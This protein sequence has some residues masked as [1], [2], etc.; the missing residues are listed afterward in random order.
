M[1]AA[2]VHVPDQEWQSD[3]GRLLTRAKGIIIVPSASDGTIWELEYIQANSILSKCLFVM[4][5]QSRRF[6]WRDRWELARGALADDSVYLPAYHSRGLLFTLRDDSQVKAA[7]PF[8]FSW[9]WVL[10]MRILRMLRSRTRA[11]VTSEQVVR[12]AIWNERARWFMWRLP[13][14]ALVAVFALGLPLLIAAIH[15]K[16]RAPIPLR[17][18]PK[19]SRFR[20]RGEVALSL[21]DDNDTLEIRLRAAAR[22]K[23]RRDFVRAGLPLLTDSELLFYLDNLALALARTDPGVARRSSVTAWMRSAEYG[24]Y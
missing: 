13:M 21:N 2:R 15:I 18:P 7:A 6:D 5:P 17:Q 3:V 12:R 16:G 10:R 23:V 1:G 24:C 11:N 19:W 22:G 8:P 9:R 4:P 14:T 20:E